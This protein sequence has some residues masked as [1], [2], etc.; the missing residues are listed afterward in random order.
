M[1]L[2][3]GGGV[4]RYTKNI[5]LIAAPNHIHHFDSNFCRFHTSNAIFIFRRFRS[6]LIYE[7]SEITKDYW[8]FFFPSG[9]K[10]SLFM[11]LI[12]P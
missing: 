10:A 6:A 11:D 8:D 2:W 5:I 3:G 9:S 7:F 4:G 1:R 12:K